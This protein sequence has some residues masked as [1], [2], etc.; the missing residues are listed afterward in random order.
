[1]LNVYVIGNLLAATLVS[2]HFAQ[3]VTRPISNYSEL[4]TGIVLY[5]TVILLVSCGFM[6]RFGLGSRF[7]KQL[8]FIHTSVTVT[9]YLTII[10]HIIHGI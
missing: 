4:D 10:M 1:M 7:I 2:I 6:V 8:R 5:A 3:Q 9:F